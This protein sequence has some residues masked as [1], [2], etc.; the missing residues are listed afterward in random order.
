MQ[1]QQSHNS[2]SRAGEVVG[3]M[4]AL[5]LRQQQQ[6]Q[7]S[8]GRGMQKTTGLSNDEDDWEA[9]WDEDDEDSDGEED[10]GPGEADTAGVGMS[11]TRVGPLQQQQQSSVSM[12]SPKKQTVVPLHRPFR[13]GMDGGHSSSSPIRMPVQ[14]SDS[15]AFIPQPQMGVQQTILYQQQSQPPQEQ[16]PQQQRPIQS[17]QAGSSS[18]VAE[19]MTMQPNR[20]EEE[21]LTKQADLVLQQG[22]NGIQWDTTSA[23]GPLAVGSSERPHMQ[24]FFPL[25]R[26]LGK[27]SFGKVVLVQ[28]RTGKERGGLFAMKILR[29]AHLVKRRQIERTKTERKVLSVVDHPFIMKLHFAF[30]T[31]DKLYLVLDYCPGGELFFHLSRYRRFPE[32]V[33]R[34]Y[35]AELILAMGHLHKRGIIYRDLKPENVLLDAEGHVKLGDFGLAKDKIKHPCEGA[36]SMCGTPEYMAPEVL[37]QAGHGFCVDYW[38]LGMLVYEMM[39]GLPPWYTTDRAKL[40]RRLK[41]APLEIPSYFSPHS[42]SFVSSLLER[43]PRRRLGVAGIRTAMDHD[44]F[45]SIHWRGLYAR[46]VE[47][48]IRPCEGWKPPEA[49]DNNGFHG[50]EGENNKGPNSGRMGDDGKNGIVPAAPVFGE[51]N[52]DSLHMEQITTDA[53]DAATAN[54][55][56]TFTRMA[57]DTDDGAHGGEYSGD[58]GGSEELHENTFVGF[59]FD[60]ADDTRK[61]VPSTART[62]NNHSQTNGPSSSSSSPM[63]PHR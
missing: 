59:T 1:Q 48:P 36:T 43:N 40:F 4:G 12:S 56:N 61:K 13:P 26:V 39:T 42:A 58:E 14:M 5:S 60:E 10:D 11:S 45:R 49:C 16:H 31:E 8:P 57:V 7:Q 62:S 55:D 19:Q 46:R 50:K 15:N 51:D 32:R 23:K 52:R 44:F 35:T 20:Q 22:E 47:A 41:S 34:F 53:L 33:A 3:K 17:M 6:Q 21:I 9:R 24:M 63:Q 25:L 37:S 54:F 29:K 38:G 30:Q 28:K 18:S 27:G 2:G